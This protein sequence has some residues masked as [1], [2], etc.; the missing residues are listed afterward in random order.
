M[1]SS[2]EECSKF[3]VKMKV[4][5][6][7]D[8]DEDSLK[9]DLSLKFSGSPFSV[10]AEKEGWKLFGITEQFMEKLFKKNSDNVGFSVSYSISKT[11]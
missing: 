4:Q 1:F 6:V 3:N 11:Q 7:N 5:E 10:D 2:E 8:Q 9:P